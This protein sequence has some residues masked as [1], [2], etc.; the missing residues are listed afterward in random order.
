MDWGAAK[1]RYRATAKTS[2]I[3]EMEKNVKVRLN[4]V[5]HVELI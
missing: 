1:F 2:N 3:D 4:D 5:P